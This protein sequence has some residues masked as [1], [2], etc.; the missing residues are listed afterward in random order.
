MIHPIRLDL[1]TTGTS[2][3]VRLPHRQKAPSADDCLPAMTCWEDDGV[4]AKIDPQHSAFA[5]LRRLSWARAADDILN[6]PPARVK[7]DDALEDAILDEFWPAWRWMVVNLARHRPRELEEHAA[8]F[9]T[10]DNLEL[11]TGVFE[12]LELWEA[13]YPDNYRTVRLRLEERYRAAHADSYDRLLKG[14]AL[15]APSNG[16]LRTPSTTARMDDLPERPGLIPVLLPQTFAF[17]QSLARLFARRPG[18]DARPGLAESRWVYWPAF[19]PVEL[20]VRLLHPSLA[21]GL[22]DTGARP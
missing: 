12:L 16:G 8:N 10:D 11:Q 9:L 2:E 18:P 20:S 6:R 13:A 3:T 21:A 5:E 7:L 15:E 1:C 14:L 22:A 17:L 19:G 4:W